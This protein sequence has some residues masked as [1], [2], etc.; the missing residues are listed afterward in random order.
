MEY[1][2]SAM[3]SVDRSLM[4]LRPTQAFLD[5]CNEVERKIDPVNPNLLHFKDVCTQKT[6]YL[7]PQLDDEKEFEKWLRK[8]FKA[9]FEE[10]VGG[11]YMD[12][13]LWPQKMDLRAFRKFFEVEFVDMVLDVEN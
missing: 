8:N 9:L 5:W 13:E 12:A 6:A 7:T 3:A 10:E 11:W 4:T 1:R 2:T